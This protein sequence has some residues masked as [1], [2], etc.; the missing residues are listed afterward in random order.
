[1]SP[2]VLRPELPVFITVKE[3]AEMVRVKVRTVYSWVE[4]GS[5]PYHKAGRITVF[6]LDEVLAWLERGKRDEGAAR[7]G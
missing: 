4:N 1:M 3:L 2:R 5:I 6:R 7:G